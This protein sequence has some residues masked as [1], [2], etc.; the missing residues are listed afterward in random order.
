MTN[1]P[2]KTDKRMISRTIQRNKKGSIYLY[3]NYILLDGYKTHLI[4]L[5]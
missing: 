1:K 3:A 5:N 4:N 2:T